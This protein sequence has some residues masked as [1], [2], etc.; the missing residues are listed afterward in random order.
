MAELS[1]ILKTFPEIKKE[2]SLRIS[3]YLNLI[4]AIVIEESSFE[5]TRQTDGILCQKVF[6]FLADRFTENISLSQLAKEFGYNEKYLSHILHELTGMHFRRLLNIYR[7]NHSRMLL[8]SCK[9]MSISEIASACGFNALNTFNREFKAV[10]GMI[11][12]EY[13]R[14]K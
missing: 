7:I 12:S 11:P 8:T 4:A 5:K 14:E 2:D 1:D 10:V 6:S 3:G 9:D 13:R